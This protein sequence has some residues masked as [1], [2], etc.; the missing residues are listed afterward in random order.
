MT[1]AAVSDSLPS[2]SQTRWLEC[3]RVFCF[4]TPG[5]SPPVSAFYGPPFGEYPSFPA[6][7]TRWFP[8]FALPSCLPFAMIPSTCPHSP[9]AYLAPGTPASTPMTGTLLPIGPDPVPVFE[10]L[11][12]HSA[13]LLVV[14]TSMGWLVVPAG[15]GYLLAIR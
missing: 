8:R 14:L 1:H 15:Q 9:V 2:L 4:P 10:T 3:W 11:G 7:V 6:A 5:F 12:H 13:D